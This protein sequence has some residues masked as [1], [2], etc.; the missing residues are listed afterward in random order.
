MLISE[1]SPHLWWER[2][3]LNKT[4]EHRVHPLF[5]QH[6][7]ENVRWIWLNS[8]NRLL[9]VLSLQKHWSSKRWHLRVFDYMKNQLHQSLPTYPNVVNNINNS[10][11]PKSVGLRPFFGELQEIP[12]YFKRQNSAARTWRQTLE[13]PHGTSSR[14]TFTYLYGS[15]YKWPHLFVNFPENQLK[16]DQNFRSD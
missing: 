6:L 8:H 7:W 9:D 4:P 10:P 2:Y 14:R 11:N 12:P 1:V 16:V 15:H 5:P 3:P 13:G